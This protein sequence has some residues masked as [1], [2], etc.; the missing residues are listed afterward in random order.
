LG[1]RID[2]LAEEEAVEAALAIILLAP[3]PPLLFMGEERASKEPFPFFCDFGPELAQS[4]T[5]G[6]R[7]EFASFPA[8]QDPGA[9]EEI[10]DPSDLRTFEGAK[11]DWG[12]FEGPASRRHALVRRL[13]EVRRR[14][15]VSRLKAH[16]SLRAVS[17][18]HG[19]KAFSVFWECGRGEV[20][21]LTANLS[22]SECPF[23]L[24][25]AGGRVLF[26]LPEGATQ[27]T[28]GGD[29]P[30]WSVIWRVEEQSAEGRNEG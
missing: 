18:A 10:P 7:E 28:R 16:F 8:F 19:E 27:R 20:L 9:R 29:L 30:G 12:A 5:E 25:G 6:R 11:L 24:T 3:A 13:L 2:R 21:R 15:I 4:V 14:E 1:E 17:V 23:S 26:E 22:H